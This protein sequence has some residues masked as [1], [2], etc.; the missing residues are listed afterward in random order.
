MH[1]VVSRSSN[2]DLARL[3]RITELADQVTAGA[4]RLA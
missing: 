4:V 2:Y 3:A 1:I